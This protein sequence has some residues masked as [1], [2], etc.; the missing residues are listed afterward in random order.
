[1]NGAATSSRQ[2]DHGAE[3]RP[4]QKKHIFIALEAKPH[5]ANLADALQ[6]CGNTSTLS[7]VQAISGTGDGSDVWQYRNQLVE[8]VA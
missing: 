2:Q 4:S 5:N 3:A 8:A 6:N 1:L 7:R